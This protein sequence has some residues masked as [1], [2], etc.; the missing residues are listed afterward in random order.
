MLSFVN[1]KLCYKPKTLKEYEK[2]LLCSSTTKNFS[3]NESNS[4]KAR[5]LI[6]IREKILKFEKEIGGFHI[7]A[8]DTKKNFSIDFSNTEKKLQRN[9]NFLKKNGENLAKDIK[10]SMSPKYAYLVN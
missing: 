5:K 7:Y 3:L 1:K 2:L 4:L 10:I 8:K 6:F 9:C